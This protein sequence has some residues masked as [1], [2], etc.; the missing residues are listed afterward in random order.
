LEFRVRA[1]DPNGDS[2]VLSAENVPVNATFVDS[3]NGS[4]SFTFTPDFTQADTYYVSF[5]ATDTLGA[6]DSEMVE[7]VVNNVNR[8]PVL[9]SIGSQSVLEGDTLEF[10]IHATDADLDSIVLDALDVPAHATFVDSGNGSG[11]FTFTPDFTQADTYYVSFIATDTLGAADSEMVEVTVTEAGNHPP[12]LDPI[13]P[14]AVSEGD[15]L[16]LRIHATDVD[17]DSVILTAENFPDNSTFV[18]SGNGAGAFTFTPDTTQAGVYYVTFK[19]SD[20]ILPDSEVVSITVSEVNQVPTFSVYSLVVL[21]ILIIVSAM[22][23]L[24]RSKK[25]LLLKNS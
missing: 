8:P 19:A 5:I 18:D 9:D 13:G 2:I 25:K 10:S 16:E 21:I 24:Y 23:N 22:G 12:E 15:T 17:G 11:S 3:G 14:K 7:I 20:G 1:T 6:T 4:G